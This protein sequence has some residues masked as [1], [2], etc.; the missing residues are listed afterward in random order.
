MNFWVTVVVTGLLAAIVVALSTF[1]VERLG[2][3]WGG[4][5]SSAPTFTALGA[6]GLAI[7]SDD[8]SEFREEMFAVP[9]SGL[10]TSFAL[11]LWKILASNIELSPLPQVLAILAIVVPCWFGVAAIYIFLVVPNINTLIYEII[12]YI[13]L[14]VIL[15]VGILTSCIIPTHSP[16]VA[17]KVEWYIYLI[18]AFA[19]G[20]A[21]VAILLLST[22]SSTFA[23]ILLEFPVI[24]LANTVFLTLSHKA[25]TPLGALGPMILGG[26]APPAMCLIYAVLRPY[27]GVALGAVG[28][29]AF[30]IIGITIPL[31][32]GLMARRQCYLSNQKEENLKFE[33]GEYVQI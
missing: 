30:T 33:L 17:K 19:G 6:I 13:A 32:L 10:L 27:W 22:R 21:V 11:Y 3:L 9:M 15:L 28:A 24:P 1:A 14:F 8:A 2:G 18:R 7:T 31:G 12:A 5:L 23:G 26:V 4:I 29:E 20:I 25:A 16:P